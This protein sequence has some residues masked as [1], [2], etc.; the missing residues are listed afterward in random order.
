[1]TQS[2]WQQATEWPM[3]VAAVVFLAAYSLDILAQ[4]TGPWKQA[5]ELIMM[6]AWIAFTIDY[7]MR[8]YLAPRRGRWFLR[9]IHEFAMVALPMFRPL[10][11]LRLVT[12]AGVVQRSG[13]AALRGRVVTYSV[14]V[15]GL[16]IL[17]GSLAMLDA[18]RHEPGAV[19]TSFSDALWWSTATVT[20]V[21]Y[22]DLSPVT[23]TGRLIAVGLMIAGIGLLGVITAT[24]ASWLVQKVGDQDEANQVATRN[25]VAELTAQIEMLRAEISERSQDFQK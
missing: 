10:R 2:R 16:L 3:I 15:T 13:G 23:G 22:G 1:M 24:L 11:L 7:L 9:N 17:V 8:L 12:L 18:E 5:V 4:P 19:I 20:T 25:Q 14:A 6:G 21:G